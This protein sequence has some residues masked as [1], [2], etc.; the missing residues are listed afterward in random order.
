MPHTLREAVEAVGEDN[1]F[2]KA[3]MTDDFIKTYMDYKFETQIIPD[4]GRPT[5]YEF[6]STYSC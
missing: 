6:I 4:E 1:D 2:L 5:P 3:V